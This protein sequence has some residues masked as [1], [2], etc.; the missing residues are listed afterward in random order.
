[1][2]QTPALQNSFSTSAASK[3]GRAR[4]CRPLSPETD[5][6]IGGGG[7]GDGQTLSDTTTPLVEFLPR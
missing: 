3:P 1:M 5:L 6:K 7:C 4:S 2:T